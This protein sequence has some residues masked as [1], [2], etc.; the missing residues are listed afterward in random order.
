MPVFISPPPTTSLSSSTKE[1]LVFPGLYLSA[2]AIHIFFLFPQKASPIIRYL[3]GLHSDPYVMALAQNLGYAIGA[4]FMLGFV[5]MPLVVLVLLFANGMDPALDGQCLL[6]QPLWPPSTINSSIQSLSPECLA[7]RRYHMVLVVGIAIGMLH[8]IQLSIAWDNFERV[9][10]MK[11]AP[12]QQTLFSGVS[13]LNLMCTIVFTLTITFIP[14][15]Y[16]PLQFKFFFTV[17][18]F[19]SIRIPGTIFEIIYE[20][21]MRPGAIVYEEGQVIMNGYEPVTQ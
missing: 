9:A 13:Y 14:I 12:V 5:L 10:L 8:H 16:L 19:S 3:N 20:L 11:K 4:L 17:L 1:A 6:E 7:Y 21:Q 2:A 15:P 18:A